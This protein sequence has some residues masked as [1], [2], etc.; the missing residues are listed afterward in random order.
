[1]VVQTLERRPGRTG[2]I[3][4]HIGQGNV[5]DYFPRRDEIVELEL[6]HLCIVCTLEPSFWQDMPEI[7]DVRLSSWL[8]SKRSSGKMAANPAH[9]AMIPVGDKSFRLQILDRDESD[10][11]LNQPASQALAFAAPMTSPL[12]ATEHASD[13]EPDRMSD[14]MPERATDRRI[15]DVVHTPDRRRVGKL[16]SNE[17]SSAAASH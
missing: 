6:D 5:R 4:L 12:M 7:H 13:R 2:S 10:R 3:G 14:G 9:V 1:M 8:E 16:K 17:F 11:A 15:K